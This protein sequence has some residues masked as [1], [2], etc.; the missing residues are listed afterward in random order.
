MGKDKQDSWTD[1]N[2]SHLWQYNQN[3]FDDLN[4]SFGQSDIDAKL[5]LIDLGSILRN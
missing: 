5:T 4:S 2:Q 3:Y 1:P